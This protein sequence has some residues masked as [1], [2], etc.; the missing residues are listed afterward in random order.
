MPNWNMICSSTILPKKE[1]HRNVEN[2]CIQ[3][4][5]VN[6]FSPIKT[7][8]SGITERVLLMESFQLQEL[9]QKQG[10]IQP[11]YDEHLKTSICKFQV[12]HLLSPSASFSPLFHRGG[13]SL[14]L[15]EAAL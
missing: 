6:S 2:N 3:L 11:E 1:K 10:E 14:A 5:I 12:T 15:G 13:A 7:G 4:Y 9:F 8:V